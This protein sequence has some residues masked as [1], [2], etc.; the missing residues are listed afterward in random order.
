MGY[1]TDFVGH[2]TLD[3]PLTKAHAD[4]LRAFNDTRRMKRDAAATEKRTDVVRIAAGLP[5]GDEGAY[6][7]GESG[8]E[9]GATGVLDYNN[10][11]KEQPGLWCQWRPTDENDGIEWDNG[12]KFYEYVG[13]LA[14]IVEH[15]LAPWGYVLN[16]EV[17]WQGEDSGDNGAIVVQANRVGTMQY[18]LNRSNVAWVE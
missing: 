13:W 14:Y 6:F 11:P 17:A 2:F 5:V 1:T 12:E 7:V 10:P 4:Y 18:E 15:F 16:G 8:Q 9:F 3:K